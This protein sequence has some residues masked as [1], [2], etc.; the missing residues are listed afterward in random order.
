MLSNWE[1]DA[2]VA[3]DPYISA[4]YGGTVAIDQLPTRLPSKPTLFIVNTDPSHLPGE[5][6]LAILASDKTLEQAASLQ[7]PVL[8]INEH[9]DSAGQAP[10]AEIQSFLNS[11]SC[12]NKRVCTS[13]YKSYMYN[14]LRV[15]DFN[16]DSCGL[17][18]LMFAYYRSRNVSFS[19]FL[20][21]FSSDLSENE[22]IV[23]YFYRMTK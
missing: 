20:S 7:H 5:H 17:F 10:G 16:S 22:S 14:H 8:S 21:M 2:Y 6:W 19:S 9:F 4:I 18:C 13:S 11:F 1:I 15:Q 23:K 12:V 3:S